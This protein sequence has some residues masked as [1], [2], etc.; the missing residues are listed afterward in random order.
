FHQISDQKNEDEIWK[1]L[2]SRGGAVRLG[3]RN[4]SVDDL[5]KFVGNLVRVVSE[6]NRTTWP[7]FGG[8]S[9]RNGKAEGDTAFMEARWRQPLTTFQAA[10]ERIQQTTDDLLDKQL[11]LLSSFFAVTASITKDGQPIPAVIYRGYDGIHAFNLKT[12]KRLW[13][14]RSD[15]SLDGSF[16]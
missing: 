16:R 9:A 14:A 3:E 7:I 5:K 15:L 10:T 4:E 1:E 6:Y 11:P 8:N 2:A 13:M 12:G